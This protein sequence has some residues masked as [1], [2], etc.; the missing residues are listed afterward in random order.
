[1]YPESE[2][3]QYRINALNEKIKSDNYAALFAIA[4]AIGFFVF[5]WDRMGFIML[6][7]ALTCKIA[8]A[9]NE[10]ILDS[11]KWRLSQASKHEQQVKW[12]NYIASGERSWLDAK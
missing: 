4:G 8:E 9:S 5:D 3:H 7:W 10:V 12:N 2:T 6:V 11:E 1:M